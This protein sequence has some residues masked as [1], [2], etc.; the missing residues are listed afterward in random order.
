ML[1]MHN[2]KLQLP[3]N[4][5]LIT[6]LQWIWRVYFCVGLVHIGVF[7]LQG[8][9]PN[10][11]LLKPDPEKAF[12]DLKIYDQSG[13][14]Y[15][16]A[17]EDWPGA[18]QRIKTNRAWADWLKAE[19]AAVQQWMNKHS[20]RVEWTA[21]WSHDFVS[22]KDG[23]Q[24]DWTEKVPGEEIQ[25]LSSPSDPQ[26]EVTPKLKAAWVRIFREKHAQMMERAARLYRLTG[27]EKFAAW[28]GGQ[29]DF[30]ATNFL[31][32]E[33]Q[34]QGA[35]LFGQALTE[36][37]NLTT[38]AQ[39]VRLLDGYISPER[40]ALWWTHLFEPEMQVLETNFP[41]VVNVTCWL[42]SAMAQV[43]LVYSNDAL[44]HNAI[45]APFGVRHQVRE[46]VTGDYLWIEQSLNYNNF[47]VEALHSLFVTAS[48]YG[49]AN[50]LTNEM[51]IVQNL[52]LA[53]LYLRF[54]TGQ[55]PN[56]SDTRGLLFAPDRKFFARIYRVFPTPIGLAEARSMHTWET[57]LDPP[58]APPAGSIQLPE[59]K[60]VNFAS[61]RMA[62]LRHG[63]WQVFFH[64]GQPPL[65][66]HLQAEALNFEAFYGE[67]DI[68]HDPG[69]VGYGSPL[70]SD[71]YIQGLNHNV[72][73]IDGEGQEQP[74]K[75]RRPD[76][77]AQARAGNLIEFCTEPPRI[78][79]EQPVYR[80]DAKAKRTLEI[81]GDRLTDTVSVSVNGAEP[82]KLGLALHLQG[83]VS[84]LPTF[85]P[86]PDF[87]RN[88]PVPFIFWRDPVVAEF[89]GHAQFDVD[90]GILTMRVRF[91]V[92]GRFRL[93]HASSPDVPPKRRT[94][95]YIETVGT[96]TTFITT[97]EPVRHD[98]AQ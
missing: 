30:Y 32:W 95:F 81:T 20:D 54:P 16:F 77:F 93:W 72:P 35:R 82:R 51:A 98:S 55:L 62:V 29:L 47:V 83:K 19:L 71:Y 87:A 65:K 8:N 26:V 67:V 25:F 90:Y 2:S 13:R 46:G 61:S 57:L 5:R 6:R 68:T 11:D 73:L 4:Q 97:F 52:L 78:T 75:G 28:A 24:L 3:S 22:P 43:A 27:E 84:E 39:V 45:D 12:P 31:R 15:R 10:M 33:P 89:N 80:S 41:T 50:A 48:V 76:P 7:A 44:W 1:G 94:G 66:S 40:K 38:F 53:P 49:R 86:D 74:P 9:E 17:R 36:A 70:H 59:V 21:G 42:R 92:P 91:H 18:C 23:S 85:K 79:A 34:R 69:T 14:P 64:Y 63:N 96:N 58:S 88:R 60:S 56:P 37:V